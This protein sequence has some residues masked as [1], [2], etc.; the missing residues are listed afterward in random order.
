MMLSKVIL[1]HAGNVSTLV[2]VWPLAPNYQ[3]ASYLS[4]IFSIYFR[5]RLNRGIGMMSEVRT[6]QSCMLCR[7]Y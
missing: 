6:T 5:H 7:P 4:L 1:L 2:S 3:V